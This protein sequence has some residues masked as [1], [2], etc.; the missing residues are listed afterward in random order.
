V[1]VISSVDVSDYLER[2]TSLAAFD[3]PV[4]LDRVNKAAIERGLLEPLDLDVSTRSQS[5]MA[6]AAYEN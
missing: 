1:E 6:Y 2:S 4:W 5:S 3:P